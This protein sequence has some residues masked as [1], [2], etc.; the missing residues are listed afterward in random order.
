MNSRRV[1]VA[2]ALLLLGTSASAK[3]KVPA[4]CK[5]YFIA[6]EN[7]NATRGAAL[8]GLNRP[9]AKW[10]GKHGDRGGFSGICYLRDASR[11]SSAS[12]SAPVYE[13]LWGETRDTEIYSY[14]TRETAT[15]TSSSSD[16]TTTDTTA[17]VPV[18]HTASSTSFHSNALLLLWSPE[19]KKFVAVATAASR[20]N[21]SRP[22][23]T[24][25]RFF[26]FGLAGAPSSSANL[27]EN[28]LKA[29]RDRE[30]LRLAK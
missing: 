27:L 1:G 28:A 29:I 26:A 16:G 15:A 8:L 6:L 23:L 3:P 18:A 14:T 22:N 12:I 25:W 19:K 9:Q 21:L 17:Q 2:V 13:I 5:V 11:I 4:P 24:S 30:R 10:Y 7:D 20:P